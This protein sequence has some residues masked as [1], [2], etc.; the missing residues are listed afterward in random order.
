MTSGFT[1]RALDAIAGL[2]QR[3]G[4]SLRLVFKTAAGKTHSLIL[5][6]EEREGFPGSFPMVRNEDGSTLQFRHAGTGPLHNVE[7]L[8][9]N[10]E[11]LVRMQERLKHVW[12]MLKDKMRGQ[13][14]LTL[15][16]KAMAVGVGLWIGVILAKTVLAALAF[17]LFYALLL[18]VIIAG[19]MVI[20]SFFHGRT[21]QERMADLKKRFMEKRLRFPE[22]AH[23]ISS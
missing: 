5:S 6:F 7:F 15:G 1:N 17:F 9:P 16:I 21:L 22:L 3:I 23:T 14:T 12:G 2:S 19:S 18:A 13:D 4:S 10:R 20:A 8:S 11:F